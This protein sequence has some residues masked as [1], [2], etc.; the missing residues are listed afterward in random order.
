MQYIVLVPD[1][2]A[3]IYTLTSFWKVVSLWF[4]CSFFVLFN[5]FGF[6][7]DQDMAVKYLDHT[8]TPLTDVTAKLSGH[9]QRNRDH[10]LFLPDVSTV[11]TSVGKMEGCTFSLSD[12]TALFLMVFLEGD[13]SL[14]KRVIVWFPAI[15]LNK[16][17]CLAFIFFWKAK[18][19]HNMGSAVLLGFTLHHLELHDGR[20]IRIKFNELF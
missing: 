13:F 17:V 11:T 5:H 6:E 3:P 15:S 10:F 20:N 12:N 4:V 16:P 14:Q 2:S 8:R 1:L 19:S 7:S 9:Q 18:G